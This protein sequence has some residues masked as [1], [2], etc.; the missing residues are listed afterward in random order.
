M[1]IKIAIAED[2]LFVGE[3][4][5]ERIEGF[6]GEIVVKKIAKN[7]AEL[8]AYLEK[9][10]DVDVILM[11]IEMPV[12]NGIIATENVCSK[13]PNV[14]VIMLTVFD[15]DENIFKAIQAGAIGYLLKDEKTE[16]IISSVRVAIEGGA[17][18]SPSIAAKALN[19]LRNPI[20]IN[21]KAYENAAN[22][23]SREIEIL[24]LIKQGLEYK[25]IAEKLFIAPSTVRKHI[26]N[27][28]RKLQAHN[29]I[30][31]IQKAIDMNL[32]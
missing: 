17:S 23:T 20:K 8:I 13:Y 10:S 32:I 4:L 26:E 27:I 19:L 15:D 31:A 6:D 2:N 25:E 16:N 28:Y 22:L 3:S 9:D 18:M 11:D 5:K 1:K 29:K 12:M 30:Q 21:E 7:G 14:K 24:E